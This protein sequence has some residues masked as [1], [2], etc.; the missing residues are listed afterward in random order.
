MSR[1]LNFTGRKKLMRTS[2]K[3]RMHEAKIGQPSSF[4]ADVNIPPDLRLS[5]QARVYVEAYVGASAMRFDFGTVA[6]IS[7]P[8]D[9]LLNEIDAGTPVLFRVKVVDETEHVGRLLAAA[10]GIRPEGDD[11]G[12]DRKALLP[13]RGCDLGEEVWHLEFDKDAGPT[14]A[15]NN[16]IPGLVERL[17]TD[18]TLM[19]A[20]YPEVVRQMATRVWASDSDFD[21]NADWLIDWTKWLIDQLGREVTS[22]DVSD[23]DAVEVIANDVARN[24]AAKHKFATTMARLTGEQES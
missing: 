4:S 10:H 21:E 19:A 5:P 9:C 1:R 20:I 7:Q 15:V 3:V 23:S 13:L 8:D 11:D 17:P 14:L 2:I 6:A 12:S 22:D 16:R 24:F 18:I